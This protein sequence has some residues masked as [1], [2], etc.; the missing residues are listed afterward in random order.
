MWLILG[1]GITKLCNRVAT[2]PC[3]IQGILGGRF[4]E[5][6]NSRTLLGV[7][8]HLE[9]REASAVERNPESI[10]H[11]DDIDGFLS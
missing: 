5:C 10:Q 4:G 7:D 11:S 6:V 9:I 3:A 8:H 1:M 2:N